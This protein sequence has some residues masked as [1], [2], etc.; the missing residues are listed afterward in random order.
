MHGWAFHHSICN[1]KNCIGIAEGENG[2]NSYNVTVW[3][4]KLYFKDHN[5]WSNF[6]DIML[7]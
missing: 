4:G 7:I 1:L 5:G 2:H 6:S 3:G